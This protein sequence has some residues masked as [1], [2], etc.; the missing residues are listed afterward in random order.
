MLFLLAVKQPVLWLLIWILQTIG[1]YGV[2]KKMGLDRKRALIPVLAEKTIG[3]TMFET[4]YAFWHPFLI[5]LIFAV[6]GLYLEPYRDRID[7]MQEAIGTIF[8]MLA[9]VNYF[10]YLIRLYRKLC[11]SF[12]KKIW[13][14]IGML[15]MPCVFLM[16]LGYGPAQFLHGPVFPLREHCT[17]QMR[18]LRSAFSFLGFAAEAVLVIAAGG[19]LVLDTLV[20]WPL[21]K[22]SVEEMHA[23]TEG[24]VS[25]GSVIRREENMPEVYERTEPVLPSRE[26][27]FPDHDDAES[28]VVLV[29]LIGSDLEGRYGSATA[30]VLQMIDASKQG[31]GLTFVLE[32]GGS[33]RWFTRGIRDRTAGRYEIRDGRL[34]QVQELDS[35]TCMSGGEELKSFL[36]WAEENYPAD[37][38]MLVLWDHGGG[39]GGGF[40]ID[41]L[42]IRQEG[43]TI[44]VSEIVSAVHDSGIR[45][46]LIGFDA[47]LMMDI[48]IAYE[49]E[50]YADYY[51]AS[52]ETEPAAGWYYTSAFGALAQ[53]PSIPTES[54]AEELIGCYDPYNVII[55]GYE[56]EE[57]TLSLADLTYVRGAYEKLR[58][59]YRK[60][61]DAVNEAEASFADIS[62]AA[63]SSYV[64]QND[65]QVD[66]ADYLHHLKTIDFDQSVVKEE[67][68]D[69]LLAAVKAVIVMRNQRSAEGINGL[70]VTFPYRNY[71][72]YTPI[73]R[74]LQHFG[75]KEAEEF[76]NIFCSIL[77][78]SNQKESDSINA[79]VTADT[80]SEDWYVKG[81][82]AYV[83]TQPLIDIEIRENGP[84]YSLVLPDKVWNS[85]TDTR[86]VFF[87]K[88]D[89][90]YRYLGSDY[91]GMYDEDGHPMI[92]ADGY[93]VKVGGRTVCYEMTGFREESVGTVYTGYVKAL[94]NEA[95]EILL[96]IEWVPESEGSDS[97]R[98]RIAGYEFADDEDAYMERGRNQ[99][100]PGEKLEFLFE[101]YDEEGNFLAKQTD[102]TPLRVLSPGRLAVTDGPLGSCVLHHGIVLT[103]VYQRTFESQ[104]TETIID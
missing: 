23:D 61:K 89:G 95:E 49:L 55:N 73:Y 41:D 21:V 13:F 70:A 11:V 94:L 80:L 68:A 51:L 17:K 67:E 62:L 98:G 88:T 34:K 12:G 52:E 42:N 57:Y 18:W 5:S 65:E 3:N 54:F 102:G 91:P 40:G 76:N 46:D 56:T 93:W 69:E 90:G 19:S 77:A 64:F 60:Q 81:Y 26:K 14:T 86:Q 53:D 1:Y 63:S 29:Y 78:F 58:E 33:Q 96:C 22:M 84:G 24:L 47:C 15:G 97:L 43:G 6:F 79:L 103:D 9:F 36:L 7:A 25:E 85:I 83:T 100:K 8:L 16:I 39:F 59:L 32:A 45:F 92:S 20:P 75:M 37:R 4:P 10:G 82:E 50:P 74:Q 71:Y 38:Y 87:Q 30:N 72:S 101:Y 2:L 99:L 27:Y 28:A 104:M 31:S 66:L 35:H 44:P 48:E